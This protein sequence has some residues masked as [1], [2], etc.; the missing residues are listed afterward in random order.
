M[1]LVQQARIAWYRR[2][3]TCDRIAGAPQLR[4]PLVIAGAGSVAF[5]RD[6]VFGWEQSPGF[7]AGL[8]AA[9][10]SQLSGSTIDPIASVMCA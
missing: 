8:N 9:F 5:G 6:I 10:A 7:H 3:W 4:A 2:L 1:R